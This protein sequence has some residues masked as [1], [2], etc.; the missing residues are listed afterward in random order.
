MLVYFEYMRKFKHKSTGFVLFEA[1]ATSE[2]VEARNGERLIRL[3]E[4]EVLKLKDFAGLL[5]NLHEVIV[6]MVSNPLE[7]FGYG[8]GIGLVSC[9]CET[10]KDNRDGVAYF[11]LQFEDI[12]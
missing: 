4:N 11:S 5:L 2:G 12:G 8:G 6:A 1:K 9:E 3:G 10:V 7:I